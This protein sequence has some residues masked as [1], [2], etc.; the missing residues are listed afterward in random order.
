MIIPSNKHI[1][2]IGLRIRYGQGQTYSVCSVRQRKKQ[3][4]DEMNRSI[5]KMDKKDES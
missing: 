2:I 3:M 1:K 5:H 4:E